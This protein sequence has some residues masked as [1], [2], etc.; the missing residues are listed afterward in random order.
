MI[1]FIIKATI[2]LG[3]LYLFYQLFLSRLK[4]FA[5]NRY[6]LLGSLVF[7][8]VIPLISIPVNNTVL[9]LPDTTG[10][11]SIR[12]SM[13]YTGV[14]VST[15]HEEHLIS[16]SILLIIYL[17]IVG[18][19]LIRFGLNLFNII[20]Q[21]RR[22]PKEKNINFTIVLVEEKVLPHTFFN[23]IMVNKDDYENGRIDDALIHHEIAH[24]KQWHSID[25][26]L[27]E[28][29]KVFFWIN[30][31]IWLM[32]KPIQLNHE[33]QADNSV[34]ASYNIN[35]YQ[36]T[37]INTVL[38]N[39]TGVLVSNFNFS[40]TKQRLKMMTRQLSPGKAAIINIAAICTVLI[41]GLTI[42]CNQDPLDE[43]VLLDDSN[44]WWQP[45]LKK[46]NIEPLAYNSFPT[47]FEMGTTNSITDGVVTLK[48]AFFLFRPVEFH[49]KKIDENAYVMLEAPYATHDINTDSIK[50][51]NGKLSMFNLKDGEISSINRY[52]FS[53]MKMFANENKF[54]FSVYEVT[55]Q[56]EI[57]GQNEQEPA[58]YHYNISV[59]W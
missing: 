17:A 41:V 9:P 2:S 3:L 19:F 6:F 37:L 44:E 39:N 48:N 53:K 52:T 56:D 46:H 13:E 14:F 30:P 38:G 10:M 33:Y 45:I 32:K 54:F 47:V 22:N 34:L 42:S 27:I 21:I 24:C 7:S 50:V 12:D 25:I 20:R 8:M 43:L 23:Y 15:V 58:K 35:R 5:F 26:L 51:D 18:V 29:V 59:R 49:E 40:L 1:D 31:F 28:L 57:L 55:S 16:A 11:I 4:T 36:H